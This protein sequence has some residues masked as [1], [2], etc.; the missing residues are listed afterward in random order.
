MMVDGLARGHSTAPE[1]DAPE[2]VGGSVAAGS[3]PWGHGGLSYTGRRYPACR[4]KELFLWEKWGGPVR[5][6]GGIVS[7][8]RRS[9]TLPGNYAAVGAEATAAEGAGP[10]RKEN[11]NGVVIEFQRRTQGASLRLGAR[12]LRLPLAK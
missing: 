1:A 8:S 5:R 3:F 12:G 11:Q 10:A 6:E 4:S 2:L 7:H 9:R